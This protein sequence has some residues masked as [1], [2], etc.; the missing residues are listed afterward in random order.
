MT[1]EWK[2]SFHEGVLTVYTSKSLS[3]KFQVSRYRSIDSP[4]V[5]D[6]HSTQSYQVMCGESFE[7]E[8]GSR[9]C[10]WMESFNITLW[11]HF[12]DTAQFDRIVLCF[13]NSNQI[14]CKHLK[15]CHCIQVG[16]WPPTLF[17][18]L[19]KLPLG[20]QQTKSQVF[21]EYRSHLK[22]LSLSMSHQWAPIARLSSSISKI[23]PHISWQNWVE[24]VYS[25]CFINTKCRHSD[26]GMLGIYPTG[27]LMY[28]MEVLL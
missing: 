9:Q 12:K 8:D 27:F 10:I 1:N 18:I 14:S 5:F 4:W 23:S 6:T 25:K 28:I 21:T 13:E 20:W 17:D 16:Y 24:C 11:Y 22:M 2:S 19:D 26:T 3:D 7:I 15:R